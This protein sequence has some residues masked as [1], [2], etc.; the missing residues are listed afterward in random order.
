MY[1]LCREYLNEEALEGFGDLREQVIRTA[2]C[3]DDLF[4]LVTEETVLIESSR[5]YGMKICTKKLR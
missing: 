5:F 3:A 1:K 2:N 4:L